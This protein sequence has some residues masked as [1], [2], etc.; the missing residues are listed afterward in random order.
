MVEEEVARA[1][2]A[3]YLGWSHIRRDKNDIEPFLPRLAGV[4]GV[5]QTGSNGLSTLR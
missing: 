5:L 4:S 1:G 2:G 3:L